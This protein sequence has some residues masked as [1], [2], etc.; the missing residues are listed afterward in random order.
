MNKWADY[1]ISEVRY[2]KD[3]SHISEVIVHL[4]QGKDLRQLGAWTVN[5]VVAELEKGKTFVTTIPDSQGKWLKGQP[6]HIV[7]IGGA[8]FIRTTRNPADNLEDLPEF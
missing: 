2:N 8:K 5:E 3:H 7:T 4:D 1:A 6:I